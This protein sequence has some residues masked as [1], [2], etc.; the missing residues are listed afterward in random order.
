MRM[1]RFFLLT[2]PGLALATSPLLLSQTVQGRVPRIGILI[3]E[4]AAGLSDRLAALRAGLAD[5]G[6]HEGRTLAFEIRSAE[7][8][9]DQLAPL[10]AELVRAR[11]DVLVAFGI[12]ALTAAKGATGQVPPVIPA[13]SSDLMALAPIRS[14]ASRFTPGPWPT[15]LSNTGCRRLVATAWPKQEG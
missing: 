5:L 4:S 14:L 2:I 10:A 7:R 11:V 12:K 9:Y 13:T 8:E 3:A 6:Y 15:R 1:R